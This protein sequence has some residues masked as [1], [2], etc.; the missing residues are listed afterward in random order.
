MPKEERK[1]FAEATFPVTTQDGITSLGISKRELY[2]AVA[3]QG[4]LSGDGIEDYETTAD[5]AVRYADALINRLD[6]NEV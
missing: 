5:N 3:M 1:R 4:L 6:Q 2:A